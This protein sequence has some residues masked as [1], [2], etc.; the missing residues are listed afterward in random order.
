VKFSV[1]ISVYYKENPQ[2]FDQALESVM[3][4]TVVPDQ[5]VLVKDG[6]LGLK[7]EE[8]IERW[9]SRYPEKFKVVPLEDNMGLATA[10]R[11][12]LEHCD[13][14]YVARMDSDDICLADR[15]EKQL[16]FLK[17]NPHVDLV[18]SYIAEFVDDSKKPRFVRQ[19]PVEDNDV[20]RMM[21]SRSPV[22]HVT[23]FFKKNAIIDSGS[24]R[25]GE[26][27]EDYDL[28]V[29]MMLNAKVIMN[30]PEV[31]VL[32]RVGDGMYKRRG[33]KRYINS[34]FRI[35]KSM[36]SAGFVSLWGLMWNAVCISVFIY[37]PPSVKM[38]TYKYFLRKSIHEL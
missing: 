1:L 32:V 34:W 2:Y 25:D 27:V 7:L 28:W 5:V 35:Q 15:F 31:L 18:G 3:N 10:L 16:L 6:P 13:Y 38:V 36:Y 4:Q 30:L 33:N 19:V 17:K 22:N 29:R 14:D 37:L 8:V 21:K 23:A 9:T 26:P 12:G 20:K 11:I 24:Y